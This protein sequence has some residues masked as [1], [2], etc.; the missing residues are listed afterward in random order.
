M[1]TNLQPWTGIPRS[2]TL[3]EVTGMPAEAFTP[4]DARAVSTLVEHF[5]LG[6]HVQ[7]PGFDPDHPGQ[8]VL[9]EVTDPGV[10]RT[11]P[12][13]IQVWIVLNL[14]TETM[15]QT[16]DRLVPTH[17]H[18]DLCKLLAGI[19]ARHTGT[20]PIDYIISVNRAGHMVCAD[21]GPAWADY[22]ALMRL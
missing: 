3:V 10:Q 20:E 2:Q 18:L 19:A 5:A 14:G 9:T 7:P 12:G 8:Y 4:A 11:D 6:L 21:T 16:P 15:W 17:F 1:S 13:S 22:A